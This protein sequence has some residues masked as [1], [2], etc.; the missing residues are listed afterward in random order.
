MHQ[1]VPAVGA[2]VKLN[3]SP[4]LPAL[5][6]DSV[7]PRLLGT[8]VTWTAPASDPRI[9]PISYRFLVNGTPATDWQSEN[10][11]TWTA[12]APGTSQIMVQV[13]DSQH[14]GAQGEGGNM[15]REFTINAPAPIVEPS[16]SP[17]S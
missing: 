15:S 13:K 6:A 4:G 2:P 12:L 7:S 11:W 3:E 9:D 1:V 16:P 10:Q 17:P 5:T 8:T 14:D